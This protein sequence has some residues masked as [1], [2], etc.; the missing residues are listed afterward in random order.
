MNYFAGLARLDPRRAV[1]REA[2]R[3]DAGPHPG[4]LLQLGLGGEREGLQDG[5][6]DLAR[7]TTAGGNTRS[8]TASATTTAPP[9]PRWRRAASRSARR[10]TG[11]SRTASSRCRIASNTAASSPM[12]PNYGLAAADAIE[13]VILREGPDT[14]G[15]LCLEPITAGGGVIVPPEGYWPRVQEICEQVRRAVA[16]RRGGLRGRA[17]PAPGSATSTTGSGPIS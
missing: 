9:S 4:L 12:R 1:R 8:C 16:H 2:D 17:A 13:E 5:A 14:V 7:V 6:P 10:S 3:Q 15:A 11:R